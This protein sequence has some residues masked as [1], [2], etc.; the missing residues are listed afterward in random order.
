MVGPT[1]WELERFKIVMEDYDNK[2]VLHLSFLIDV[3]ATKH[4]AYWSQ[5][6]YLNIIEILCDGCVSHWMWILGRLIVLMKQITHLIHD[7]RQL[8]HTSWLV[9]CFFSNWYPHP[10]WKLAFTNSCMVESRL[11]CEHEI[12]FIHTILA[13]QIFG[14]CN[15]CA[16]P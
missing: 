9:C 14:A 16:Q 7:T 12:F 11:W 8:L 15:T 13:P 6:E 1:C 10:C 3:Q 5:L 4:E 2:V